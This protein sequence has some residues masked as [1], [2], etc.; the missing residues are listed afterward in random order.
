V[1]SG[2]L[3][4]IEL[5]PADE[6]G[7]IF[8]NLWRG[9]CPNSPDSATSGA[10]AEGP[11]IGD[12]EHEARPQRPVI[13]VVDDEEPIARMMR[14]I[15]EGEGGDV[16][17]CR[18]IDETLGHA[19]AAAAILCDVHLVCADGSKEDGLDLVRRLRSRG[20]LRP[21]IMVSGDHTRETVLGSIEAGTVDYLLK[22][23]TKPKLLEK[24]HKQGLLLQGPVDRKIEDRKMKTI[25]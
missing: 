12:I 9:V 2:E 4:G 15:I 22:P 18:T 7:R 23:F 5:P 3:F 20:Y 24:L 6:L 16:V 8:R 13:L 19:D 11:A 10:E 17:H 14:T 1:E 21:I 25:V